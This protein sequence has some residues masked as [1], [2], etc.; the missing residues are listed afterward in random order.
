MYYLRTK[1]RLNSLNNDK[2]KQKNNRSDVKTSSWSSSVAVE[3]EMSSEDKAMIEL[4]KNAGP[5]DCEMC[6]S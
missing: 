6:G 2:K 4:A 3:A 5:D 1:A